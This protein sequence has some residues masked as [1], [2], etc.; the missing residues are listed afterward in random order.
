MDI[1]KP[2][3]WHGRSEF[4]KEIGTIVIGVLI[5]IGGEQLVE[6]LHW[7]A[8]MATLR[9]SSTGPLWG[10]LPIAAFDSMRTLNKGV[11]VPLAVQL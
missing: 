1:H 2:K 7:R 4:L 9:G 3:P 6:M 8:V 5:A 10:V 11:D